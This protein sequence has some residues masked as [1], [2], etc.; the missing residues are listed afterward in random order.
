MPLHV[1]TDWLHAVALLKDRH[2]MRQLMPNVVK[3]AS[4]VCLAIFTLIIWP[5]RCTL[6]AALHTFHSKAG[7]PPPSAPATSAVD[8]PNASHTET[9]ALKAAR[10]DP[11]AEPVSEP[12][13]QAAAAR[14]LPADAQLEEQSAPMADVSTSAEEGDVPDRHVPGGSQCADTDADAQLQKREVIEG[15]LQ[16]TAPW[17]DMDYQQLATDAGL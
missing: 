10:R 11:P 5:C 6:R 17:P 1:P 3:N 8:S 4:T 9:S 2:K 15:L 14:N 12:S 7:L 13:A 16:G